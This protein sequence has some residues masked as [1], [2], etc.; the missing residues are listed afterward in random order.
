MP[1]ENNSALSAA[2]VPMRRSTRGSWS[3]RASARLRSSSADDTKGHG[4]A[5]KW[6][7]YRPDPHPASGAPPYVI[8][9]TAIDETGA[10]RPT[11]R[12]IYGEDG[13]LLTRNLTNYPVTRASAMPEF[14]LDRTV[15]PT[16]VNPMGAK[17]A[18]DVCQP[19][20]APAV[21][22][23]IIDALSDKGVTHMDIPVTPEKIWRVLQG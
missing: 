14:R 8:T 17:G 13:T 23:A 11:R 4:K 3:L 1:L 16:P 12:F 10:G 5:D 15:T 22:N 9:S 18:G 21:V 20:V 2:W 19:A 7:T 6:D